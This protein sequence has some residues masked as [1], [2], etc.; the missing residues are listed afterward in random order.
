MVR[1]DKAAKPPE[2]PSS[3]G[4]FDPDA[5]FLLATKLHIPRLPVQHISRPRLLTLLEQS[6]Q[7]P[8]TLVAA[9]AGSG[10][11]TLLAEWTSTTA[12]PV[13][14]LSLEAT[15]NDPARLLAYLIA[16]LARLDE[17]F[18][19]TTQKYRAA[20]PLSWEPVMIS[21]INDL[22]AQLQRDAVVILDDYHL[23]T[24]EA[25]YAVLQFL[26]DHLPPR[27]HLVIGTRID[28]P[29][30]LARL[31]SRNQVSELRTAELRFTS[32]ETEA[33]AQAM[34]YAFSDETLDL[35]QQ[36]TEGWIAGVQLL[37]LALHGPP[38]AR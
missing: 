2:P 25:V 33:F 27:L 22:T 19:I 26:F 11:T 18:G 29:L 21:L 13:S 35:L 34:G 9:P 5:D 36:R 38:G 31:R 15:E 23:L 7:R 28:P 14:W 3:R 4:E 8:L 20:L 32:A 10:K 17:H 1:A 6:V 24:S 37:M 12:Y 16:A 30:P